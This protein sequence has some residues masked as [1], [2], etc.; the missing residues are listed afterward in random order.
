M[1]FPPDL[2]GAP[3]TPQVRLGDRL[4]ELIALELY[5]E[6]RISSGKGAQLLGVLKLEFAR[7]L[8]QHGISG[9]RQSPDGLADEVAMVEGL[10]GES[11]A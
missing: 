4:R 8:A 10:W 9:F 3:D 1:E 7:P 11:S 5:R 2:L 6:G